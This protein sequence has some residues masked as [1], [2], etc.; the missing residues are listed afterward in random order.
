MDDEQKQ[1]AK[2]VDVNRWHPVK[3]FSQLATADVS[4]VGVKATEG[5]HTVDKRLVYHRDG[6]RALGSKLD[7]IIY[8]HFARSGD[9]ADQ[10]AMLM[11]AVGALRANER[12]CVDLEVSLGDHVDIDDWLTSFFFGVHIRY[13]G[14]KQFVYTSRRVW[15]QLGGGLWPGH[16]TELWAPRYN[17]A[18]LEPRIPSPWPTWKIWQWTD[19]GDHGPSFSCPGI[20]EC[21][22]NYWNGDVDDLRKWVSG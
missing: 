12:L 15:N 6:L 3:D 8:Y 19:G 21:D 18:D 10:S 5:L 4:F 7:L 1:R 11:S 20:G 13:P 9:P 17:N 14:K 2:G 22:A 16:E